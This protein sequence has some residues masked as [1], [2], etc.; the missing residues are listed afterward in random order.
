MLRTSRAY[1]SYAYD[2]CANRTSSHALFCHVHTNSCVCTL[3]TNLSRAKQRIVDEHLSQGTITLSILEGN[4]S[5]LDSTGEL[6]A[7]S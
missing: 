3:N 6:T 2:A 7:L 1:N 4:E 5:D